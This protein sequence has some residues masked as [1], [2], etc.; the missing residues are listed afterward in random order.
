MTRRLPARSASTAL[1]L[2]GGGARAAYQVGVLRALASIR[3]EVAAPRGNPFGIIAGTSAGAINAAAL[4]CQADRF[5]MA[6]AGLVNVW[7]GFSADQV[8]RADAFGVVRSGA[9][10][11]TMLTLGWAVARWRRASPRSLLDNEPL[12][13]LLA[14]AVPLER[15]PGLLADGYLQALAVTASSYTSGNHVT[16]LLYT[17]PSPRD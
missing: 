9:R 3:R 11:L 13:E 7:R 12:A 10:W 8:Y 4:A 16:C 6:V 15:L 1:V 17:S 2:M 14:R 5:D